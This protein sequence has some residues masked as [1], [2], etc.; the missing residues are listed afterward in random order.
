[1]FGKKSEEFVP[2]MAN[3]LHYKLGKDV[4]AVIGLRS[5]SYV[6]PAMMCYADNNPVATIKAYPDNM[7]DAIQENDVCL[8]F[9]FTDDEKKYIHIDK[10]QTKALIKS[11]KTQLKRI[12][13]YEEKRKKYIKKKSAN[14]S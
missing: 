11:L 10:K 5:D 12:E 8:K 1:M 7:F 9:I 6:G 4:D 2:F 13:K 14:N 3:K